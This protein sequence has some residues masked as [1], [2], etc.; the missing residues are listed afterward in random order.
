MKNDKSQIS[1]NELHQFIDRELSGSERH[2]ISAL[3]SADEALR[4]KVND[5]ENINRKLGS[6]FD[7]KRLPPIS[8]RSLLPLPGR[9]SIPRLNV[10]ASLLLVSIGGLL[11][12]SLNN[13]VA[14]NDF[15]R[16]LP[17]EAA[18]AHA[19]YVPEVLHPVEVG[20]SERDHLNAWLSKRL[21]RPVVAPDLRESG[22][23][24]VGGRLLPDQHRAAA[25]FMFEDSAGERMT[26]YI[27][28]VSNSTDSAFLH[29]EDSDLGIIYW[30]DGG[31]AYAL[32]AAK[33]KTELTEI[34]RVVYRATN[35]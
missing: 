14:N 8:H 26:L 17:V 35:P 15:T 9:S 18:F 31:L 12:Y 23:T 28:Q 7:E 13:L 2:R 20:A 24:L 30:V 32:T 4:K 34:A 11:G 22:F 33:N 19:V 1:E 27:R 16:P 29:A 10:A 3:I 6:A 5:C 21:D 25:Q